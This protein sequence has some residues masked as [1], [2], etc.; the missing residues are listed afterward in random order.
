MKGLKL[1]QIIDKFGSIIQNG[2]TV[3]IDDH[4]VLTLYASIPL[5][6]TDNT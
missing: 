3:E 5:Y 6:N 4:T 2:K 1:Q